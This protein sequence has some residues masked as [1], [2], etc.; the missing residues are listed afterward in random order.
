MYWYKQT[1]DQGIA[2]ATSRK[3][4]TEYSIISQMNA[5][6]T[7]IVRLK[8]P[9]WTDGIRGIMEQVDHEQTLEGL[10]I[11]CQVQEKEC[12]FKEG[13]MSKER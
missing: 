1:L 8:K 4:S 10:V 6:K 2:E 11:F 13:Y 5:E 7:R 12:C 3:L 9:P